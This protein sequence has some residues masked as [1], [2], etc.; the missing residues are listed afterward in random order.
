MLALTW[1]CERGHELAGGGKTSSVK[2]QSKFQYLYFHDNFLLTCCL[3]QEVAAGALA[4]GGGGGDKREKL[5]PNNCEKY[6]T[7]HLSPINPEK[8][9]YVVVN[10]KTTVK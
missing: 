4:G 10:L 6:K 8:A 3:P 9:K 7:K 2:F 5:L 1:F